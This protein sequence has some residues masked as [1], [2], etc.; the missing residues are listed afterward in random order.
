MA[1]TSSMFG[2]P[3][4]L[5]PVN[6][7]INAVL[8]GTDFPQVPEE[9]LFLRAN[10]KVDLFME[11][12]KAELTSAQ[13]GT[14]ALD[15][16]VTGVE[17]RI[18]ITLRETNLELLDQVLQGFDLTPN[19]GVPNG[20]VFTKN[21]GEQDSE[22]ATTMKLVRLRAG[23]ESTDPLDTVY[24][25]LVAPQGMVQFS[26]DSATQREAKITFYIYPS[27]EILYL[28]KPVLLFGGDI[29]TGGLVTIV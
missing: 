1:E 24:M 10:G 26:Y 25:P 14:K 23:A 6:A 2:G 13:G 17:A 21:I 8:P 4:T 12:E 29:L 22:I 20:F 27:D 19:S 7:Y 28:G 15:R 18:E 5:G 11:I 16:V 9:E 3:L